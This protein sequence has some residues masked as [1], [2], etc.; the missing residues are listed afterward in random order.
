MSDRL[1][2]LE[3]LR[4]LLGMG[5]DGDEGPPT[6][7]SPRGNGL[8]SG[9]ED[10][11][12]IPCEEAARRVYEYLDGELDDED[13]EMIRCHV[14]QCERCYPMFDWEEMFLRA[15]RERGERPEPNEELRQ[16]VERIL[17]RET[18]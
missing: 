2:L 7:R 14:E 11:E 6:P 10:V 1:E 3:R 9:C 18:G 4:R 15:V 8:P 13:T 16:R 12:E 5:R 17:D